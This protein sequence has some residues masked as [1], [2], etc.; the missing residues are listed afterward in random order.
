MSTDREEI[1]AKIRDGSYFKD[2]RDWYSGKY[3]YPVTE[4][5]MMFLF[6]AAALFALLPIL[7]LVKSTAQSNTAVPVP[8]MVDDAVEHT[9][10]ISKLATNDESAQEA[11]AKYLITDYLKSRE[12]YSYSVMSDSDKRRKLLKKIKSSSAK[13]VL[14]EYVN[15]TSDSNPYSPIA[16]YKDHTSRAVKIKSFSFLDNDRTSGKAK[17]I[18]EAIEIPN[19]GN[20]RTSLWEAIINFRLPDVATI[21]KTGAPLRF[22]AGYYRTK[23]LES[24]DKNATVSNANKNLKNAK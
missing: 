22:I 23:Q 4:R 8:I 10:I 2:A 14:N 19:S 16:R 3:L 21:A 11:V 15:Y 17:I 1:A 9:A 12:E 6:A 20:T 5:A 24:A 7:T 13:S 18:F